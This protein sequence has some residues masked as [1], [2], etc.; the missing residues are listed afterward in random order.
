MK[1]RIIAVRTVGVAAA[2]MLVAVFVHAYGVMQANWLQYGLRTS[3]TSLP[4]PT[5]F[6]HRYSF[7]GYVLPLAALLG[8]LIR[9]NAEEDQLSQAGAFLWLV[10]I[11]A[12]AWL[13]ASILS[14]QLPLYYPV[15]V[16]K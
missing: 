6:F 12:L 16:I 10:G 7:L 2:T 3:L 4:S 13:F 8:I 1:N 11:V 14:W 15:A 5:V 9:K